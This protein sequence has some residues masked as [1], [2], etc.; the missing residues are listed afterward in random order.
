[1]VDA[2]N[3]WVDVIFFAVAMQL[4]QRRPLRSLNLITADS[5]GRK[6]V[7]VGTLQLLLHAD[8]NFPKQVAAE[9]AIKVPRQLTFLADAEIVEN[10]TTDLVIREGSLDGKLPKLYKK[11]GCTLTLSMPSLYSLVHSC[12]KNAN[13]SFGIRA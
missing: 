13:L 2:I 7:P 6:I 8:P 11:K 3:A 10:L 5:D 9:G 12:T 1:M 4:L